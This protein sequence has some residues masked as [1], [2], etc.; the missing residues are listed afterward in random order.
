LR[1]E[2]DNEM[3]IVFSQGNFNSVEIK[4]ITESFSKIVPVK[5][6]YY[7][8]DSVEALS[9]FLIFSI[10][11]VLGSVGQGFFKAIGS[12]L[13]R[14]AKEKV[15]R[16]LKNK[17]NPKVIFQMSYKSTTISIT[18]QTKD[19]REL[20]K[21]FD[22]IDKAKDIAINELDRQ[23]TKTSLMLINYDGDWILEK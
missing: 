4:E 3:R 1:S 15:I 16:A 8:Q 18:S 14:I 2:K 13:Y 22:T 10:G 6:Q 23:R 11:Y 17:Q 19:E 7:A 9:P 21:I 5:Q 12:D 20:N